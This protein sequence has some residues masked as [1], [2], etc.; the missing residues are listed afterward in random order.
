MHDAVRIETV[1]PATFELVLPLIAAYQ[2]FYGAAPDDA[3]NRAHFG[4]FLAGDARGIQFV[5][6]AGNDAALGF[7]TLYFPFSSVVAAA[8]CLMNDLFVV[9]Q[10]RGRGVGRALIEHCCHYAGEH[11]FASLSWQTAQSNTVAQRLY[12]SIDTTQSAWYRYVMNV[13]G[14][15]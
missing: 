12:D 11:G 10:A 4:R 8:I 7:A 15:L 13:G 9:P 14:E 1:T 5:A 2:Q 6:L 3:R